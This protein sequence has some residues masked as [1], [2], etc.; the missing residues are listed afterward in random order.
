MPDVSPDRIAVISE[1]ARIPIEPASAVRV[2]GAIAM[3]VNRLAASNLAIPL[4]I[5]PS[6][7]MVIQQGEIVR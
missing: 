3:P 4:E 1:A 5:E 7:F 2:A 6:T